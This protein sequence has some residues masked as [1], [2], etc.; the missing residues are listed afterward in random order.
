VFAGEQ[1][2]HMAN[3]KGVLLPLID[4]HAKFMYWSVRQASRLIPYGQKFVGK[5]SINL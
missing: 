4:G 5:P 2:F 1:V 3:N